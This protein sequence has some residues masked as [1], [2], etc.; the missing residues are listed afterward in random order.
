MCQT[1]RSERGT[2]YGHFYLALPFTEIVNGNHSDIQSFQ[3]KD[4]RRVGIIKQYVKLL[5]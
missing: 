4:S 2:W 1:R 5:V 3:S